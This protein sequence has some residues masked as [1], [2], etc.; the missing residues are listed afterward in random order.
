MPLDEYFRLDYMSS[1]S[2]Y[3]KMAEWGVQVNAQ[4][5][6][7]PLVRVSFGS[8]AEQSRRGT[9]WGMQSLR[10]KYTGLIGEELPVGFRPGHNMVYHTSG[11]LA[12][13]KQRPAL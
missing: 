1:D 4:T 8:Q 5:A 10:G 2:L 6:L 9:G 3:F 11:S 12:T 13:S 7:R